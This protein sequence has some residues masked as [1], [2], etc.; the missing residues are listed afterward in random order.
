MND[1]INKIHLLNEKEYNLDHILLKL[2]ENYRK[3]VKQHVIE[4]RMTFNDGM[5]FANTFCKNKIL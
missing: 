2:P 3:K 1:C 5:G 4:K